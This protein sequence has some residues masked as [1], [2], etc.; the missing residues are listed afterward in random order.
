M[1]TRLDIPEGTDEQIGIDKKLKA[2]VI[3]VMK[4]LNQL[5]AFHGLPPLTQAQVIDALKQELRNL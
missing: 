1:A 5:R 3:L 4:Q 2:V